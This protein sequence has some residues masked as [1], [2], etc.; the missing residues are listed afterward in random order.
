MGNHGRKGL[1]GKMLCMAGERTW[2]LLLCLGH[3]GH[4]LGST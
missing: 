2:A 3:P 4:V 1:C